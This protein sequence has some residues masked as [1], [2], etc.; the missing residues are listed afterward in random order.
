M[1]QT[2]HTIEGEESWGFQ[3]DHEAEIGFGL[4]A[5]DRGQSESRLLV[6]TDLGDAKVHHGIITVDQLT[7]RL[8]GVRVSGVA[9]GSS[10]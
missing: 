6:G 4:D 1:P 5:D 9:D 2:H 10:N 8:P 3:F 7:V